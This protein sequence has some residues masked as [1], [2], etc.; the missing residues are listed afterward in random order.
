MESPPCYVQVSSRK[1]A[2]ETRRRS[3]ELS[4]WLTRLEEENGDLPQVEVDEMLGLVSDV[5]AEVTPDD[6]MP[7]RVVL[8]VELLLDV[9]GDVLLNVVLLQRLR[10]AI[11][12]VLLHVLGHV[13]ILDD[14]FS[15]GHLVGFSD[16]DRG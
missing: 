9:S 3:W 16:L 8:F 7:R 10:R 13:R 11:D 2:S 1:S 4:F 15:V 12:G 5:A 14:G 6:A